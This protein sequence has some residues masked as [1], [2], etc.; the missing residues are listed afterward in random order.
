VTFDPGTLQAIQTFALAAMLVAIALG[1]FVAK[2][3]H[4]FVVKQL[5]KAQNESK[6]ARDMLARNNDTLEKN[7]ESLTRMATSVEKLAGR[8]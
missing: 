4:D 3:S 1:I 7:T 6:E 2:P 5:E 8:P